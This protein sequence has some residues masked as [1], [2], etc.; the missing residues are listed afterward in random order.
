MNCTAIPQRAAV[1]NKITIVLNI[2]FLPAPYCTK[3]KM[4]SPAFVINPASKDPKDNCPKANN[5][6]NTT[7]AAQLGINPNTAAKIGWNH[8]PFNKMEERRSIPIHSMHKV[9]TKVVIK[10]NK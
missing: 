7:V 6:H 2:F 9:S 8:T 10:I 5:W 3:H 1:T 4:P